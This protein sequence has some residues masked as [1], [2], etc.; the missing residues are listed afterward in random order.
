MASRLFWH[1][2]VLC[3]VKTAISGISSYTGVNLLVHSLINVALSGNWFHCGLATKE[4]LTWLRLVV[5]FR[6]VFLTLLSHLLTVGNH[7]ARHLFFRHLWASHL[8][9]LRNH[10]S[11]VGLFLWLDG[12]LLAS[13]NEILLGCHCLLRLTLLLLI[14]LFLLRVWLIFECNLVLILMSLEGVVVQYLNRLD[15]ELVLLLLSLQGL[16]LL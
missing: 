4:S 5:H 15:F 11:L 16:S 12:H 14:S 1:N 2:T 13:A 3:L 10:H 8:L 7:D 9:G 6:L